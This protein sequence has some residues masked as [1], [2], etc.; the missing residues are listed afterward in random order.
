MACG[1][2][3]V[4]FRV[5]GIPDV[6]R[7]GETGYLARLQNVEDLAHGLRMFLE[8]DDWCKEIARGCRR[9]IEKGYTLHAEI[10]QFARLYKELARERREVSQTW[11]GRNAHR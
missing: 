4:A 7:D 3:V 6:V 1:T 2:P 11:T 8:P 5:G 10:D 9:T